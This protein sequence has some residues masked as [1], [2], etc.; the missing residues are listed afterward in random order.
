MKSGPGISGTSAGWINISEST[1]AYSQEVIK[2]FFKQH[3]KIPG[4]PFCIFSDQLPSEDQL[5]RIIEA[6]RLHHPSHTKI[7]L[8]LSSNKVSNTGNY[9][10][11]ISH[12]LYDIIHGED[13]NELLKYLDSLIER[14]RKIEEILNTSV[15]KNYLA[16]ES[17]IWKNFLTEVIEASIFCDSSSILLIGESGTGKELISRLIHT[18][19]KRPAKK[20]LVLLDCTTIVPELSGSEFFGHE[21]GSYTNAMQSREGAFAMANN[22]TLFL[23]EIGD[24]PIKMQAELLR[25]IQEGAYKKVGSNNW[26]KTSFRL[27]SATHRNLRHYINENKFRQDLYFRVADI[28]LHVPS[29]KER[30]EDIIVLANH[31][32]KQIFKEKEVPEFD[33]CVA[34]YLLQ[35]D[36]PGNV[37]EL[38]QLIQRISMKHV[39]HSKITIGEIPLSDRLPAHAVDSSNN[40]MYEELSLKKAILSGAS[41]WDL[42]D[43]TMGEAINAALEITRGNKKLAAEKL[44]VTPRAVQQ[45]LKNKRWE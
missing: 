33:D 11:L 19:D 45:Y 10:E 12:G 8:V 27:I 32:L 22:G 20:D 34:E 17:I 35:R 38:K 44:G 31:F 40:N 7:I 23:D 18:L 41:L 9:W 29:L 36:Y 37:R 24:L 1:S 39:H 42:K 43:K 28:E 2:N 6:V 4:K 15:I 3:E 21:R 25:V 26:Q 14:E 30:S 16:G 5:V 13:E